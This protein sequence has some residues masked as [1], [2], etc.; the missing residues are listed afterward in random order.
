MSAK[1]KKKQP[2]YIYYKDVEVFYCSQRS[3]IIELFIARFREIKNV[4]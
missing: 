3:P 2:Q 4:C 1:S